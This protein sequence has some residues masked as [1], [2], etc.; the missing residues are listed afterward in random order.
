MNYISSL[1]KDGQEDQLAY[2]KAIFLGLGFF[3]ITATWSL[4]N[5]FVP[6]FLKGFIR[7]ESIIGLIMTFDNIA[8]ITLQPYF[9][10]L[11]DNTD[12]KYGH[13]LPFLMIGIPIAAVFFALIP[14]AGNFWLLLTFLIIMNLAM[15][16]FRSPTIALMPDLTPS[17]L[18]SKANGV[19][20]FM[21]G[22]GAVLTYAVG[23]LLYD[24]HPAIPFILFALLLVGVLILYL[25]KLKEPTRAKERERVNIIRVIV[26]VF[27]AKDKKILFVLFAIFFWFFGYSGVEAFFTLYGKEFLGIKESAAAFSLTF[28]SLSFVIFAIPSGLLASKIG[29]KKTI[30]GGI[31]G[32]L[33]IF[34]GLV[35][36]RDLLLI[37]LA[38]LIGGLFWAF[39]NINSYPMVVDEAGKKIGAYTGVY[40]F[41]S[42]IPAILSPVFV[43][44]LIEYFSYPVLF[45]NSV[46][47]FLIALVLMLKVEGRP[48]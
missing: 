42:T 29:R 16:V 12:S 14:F 37:R 15:S 40:Y 39:I 46:V 32:L 13:R 18:R 19:I 31:I 28:F 35:V 27:Q 43:G 44:R 24:I 9:G 36:I 17:P 10:A 1:V 38:L 22:I 4:Y 5:S 45:I 34:A 23:S 7:S 48:G 6:I 2:G 33:V 47:S 30:I 20:N 41:F 25:W 3:I 26:E 11:S 21:G 8:A